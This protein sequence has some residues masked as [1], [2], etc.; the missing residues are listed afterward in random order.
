[1]TDAN[2]VPSTLYK[3]QSYNE[4]NLC[5]LGTRQLWFSLPTKFDDPFDCAIGLGVPLP[6]PSDDDVDRI[7]AC[8]E[9]RD[10]IS[11]T[12]SSLLDSSGK[13]RSLRECVISAYMRF[14]TRV[15]E[16]VRT[17]FGVCC[18]S[19]KGS[20]LL[21]WSQYAEAHRG[22]CLVFHGVFPPFCSAKGVAYPEEP[23]PDLV[24]MMCGDNR[25]AYMAQW[26]ICTKHHEWGYQEEWRLFR[27]D[28]A[29]SLVPYPPNSLKAVHFGVNMQPEHKEEVARILQ[30]SPTK[31]YNM[32][33]AESGFSIEPDPEPYVPT[34]TL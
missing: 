1:M 25:E 7:V 11:V 19:A 10:G 14:T 18:L 17:R 20:D 2:S 30:G 12:G 29:D 23:A 34:C 28:K 21:M 13:E 5:N 31:L 26:F 9:Q 4:L 24:G 27:P 6:N 3:Y 33:R 22:F 16:D 8:A 15:Y 32:K